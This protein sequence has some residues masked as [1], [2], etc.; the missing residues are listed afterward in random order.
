VCNLSA[1]H[2]AQG[3]TKEAPHL[4]EERRK[5]GKAILRIIGLQ[6]VI[7]FKTL[8]KMSSKS[9]SEMVQ[10][11]ASMREILPNGPQTGTFSS[12]STSVAE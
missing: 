6:K 7:E 4:H 9:K 10:H 1:P 3:E 12:T 5:L 11:G 8:D 2:P